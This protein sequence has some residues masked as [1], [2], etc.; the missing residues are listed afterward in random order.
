MKNISVIIVTAVISSLA[1]TTF[2][3]GIGANDPNKAALGTDPNK[4]ASAV[5]AKT[6][7]QKKAGSVTFDP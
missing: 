1:T 7:S 3:A 6:A 2:A 4:A 5:K